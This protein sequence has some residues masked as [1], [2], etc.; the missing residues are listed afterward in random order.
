MHQ[1]RKR[2][3]ESER[4]VDL[5][6]RKIGLNATGLESYSDFRYI[7]PLAPGI[8]RPSTQKPGTLN[9]PNPQTLL[10]L[11]LQTPRPLNPIALGSK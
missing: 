2:E 8:S 5:N 11:A 3:G 9:R 10:L 6:R 7:Q 4:P 1:S